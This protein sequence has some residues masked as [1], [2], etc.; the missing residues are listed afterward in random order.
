MTIA[1]LDR[2]QKQ[3]AGLAA[4]SVGA[5]VGCHSQNY[6]NTTLWT[7]LEVSSGTDTEWGDTA[8]QPTAVMFRNS[9]F[10]PHTHKQI[11]VSQLSP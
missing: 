6:V 10:R 2:G 9:E 1:S 3:G 7:H 11:Y 8:L 5:D 4:G